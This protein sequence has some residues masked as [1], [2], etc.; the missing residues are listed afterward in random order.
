MGQAGVSGHLHQ[1]VNAGQSPHQRPQAT[2]TSFA[3]CTLR[4]M[5]HLWELPSKEALQT[6]VRGP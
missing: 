4:V 3:G 2:N 1:A 5:F 6:G